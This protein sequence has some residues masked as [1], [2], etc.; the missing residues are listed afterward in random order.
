MHEDPAQRHSGTRAYNDSCYAYL[1]AL[2]KGEGTGEEEEE[3]ERE[4]GGDRW[5]WQPSRQ[6]QKKC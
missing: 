1:K 4:R 3:K 2:D 5:H 6:K